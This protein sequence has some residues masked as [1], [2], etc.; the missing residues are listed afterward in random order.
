MV[1]QRACSV[2]RTLGGTTTDIRLPGSVSLAVGLFLSSLE[3][4]I[5]ATSLVYISSDLGSFDKSNWVVT[6]YL[7]TYT[8]TIFE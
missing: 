7:L 1:S 4:T 6:S 5:I 2:T 8:G 3:T